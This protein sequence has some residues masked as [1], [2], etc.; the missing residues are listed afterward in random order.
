MDGNKLFMKNPNGGEEW[1]FKFDKCIWSHD[2][3][4]GGLKTNSHVYED[5]GK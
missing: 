3:S 5:L 1:E 4:N 2:D